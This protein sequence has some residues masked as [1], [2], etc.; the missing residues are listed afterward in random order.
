LKNVSTNPNDYPQNLKTLRSIKKFYNEHVDKANDTVE[1]QLVLEKIK[2]CSGYN[3]IP[4]QN[5]SSIYKNYNPI[6]NLEKLKEVKLFLKNTRLLNKNYETVVK[7]YDSPTTFFFADP[8][9]ENTDKTFY[10]EKNTF[11]YAHFANVLSKIQGYVMITLND[12]SNIRSLFKDFEIK[13]IKAVNNWQ[14]APHSSN[15]KQR[16]ELI[17]MNYTLE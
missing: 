3:N 8:P 7:T 4:V 6:I 13:S 2:S 12:S 1:N 5:E 10:N 9:Y 15:K 14:N 17:I 16:K 11:D